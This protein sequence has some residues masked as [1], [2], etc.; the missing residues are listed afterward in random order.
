[1]ITP[2]PWHLIEVQSMSVEKNN[3]T[4]LANKTPHIHAIITGGRPDDLRLIQ[5]APELLESLEKIVESMLCLS[6]ENR[7]TVQEL[8]KFK[9]LT[10]KARGTL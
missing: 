3:M 7:L 2:A 9:E 4:Y 8:I 10:K 1:M 5:Y 6:S